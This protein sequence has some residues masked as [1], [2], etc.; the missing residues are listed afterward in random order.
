MNGLINQLPRRS[1]FVICLI[2]LSTVCASANL[3]A[4]KK[5]TPHESEAL[6]FESWITQAVPKIQFPESVE[7]VWAIAHGSQMGPG[8]GWFHS[9]VGRYDWKWLAAQHGVDPDGGK[10]TRQEFKGSADLFD[11]LDRDHDG[12]LTAEDF[13]WSDRSSYMRASGQLRPWFRALDAN[14]NGRISRAEWDEFFAKGSKG[15]SYLSPDDL[16]E[17]LNPPQKKD[18][19]KDKSKDEPSPWIFIKGLLSSEL[20]SFHEGPKLGDR[21]PDF[22]LKTQDGRQE[23][24]LSQFRGQKPVVLIFGSFT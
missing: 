14:S 23:I 8:E 24:R 10:I 17:M 11:R 3:A 19:D 6:T 5:A 13:D 9:G 2:S 1:A 7:M 22:T 16:R 4:E 20:G 18:K 21:A 15:K 12:E